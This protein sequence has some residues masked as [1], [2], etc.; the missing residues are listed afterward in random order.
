MRDYCI[1]VTYAL[2]LSHF[3]FPV[4]ATLSL[5]RALCLLFEMIAI[6]IKSIVGGNRIVINTRSSVRLPCTL[7]YVRNFICTHKLH[8][9]H[10]I[11]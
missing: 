10:E 4:R 2:S 5:S 3:L 1:D 8:E 9:T 7:S 11:K 6:E